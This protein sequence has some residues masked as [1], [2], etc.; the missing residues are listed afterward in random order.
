ME[1]PINLVFRGLSL[2]LEYIK[3]H[4]ERFVAATNMNSNQKFD[5]NCKNP[6]ITVF[7]RTSAGPRKVYMHRAQD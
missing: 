7:F 2:K 4:T 6:I 1:T 3:L 5:L